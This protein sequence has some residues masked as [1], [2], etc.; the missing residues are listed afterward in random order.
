MPSAVEPVEHTNSKRHLELARE[1]AP[2]TLRVAGKLDE[3]QRISRVD[4]AAITKQIHDAERV[5]M[6]KTRTDLAVRMRKIQAEADYLRVQLRDP[7]IAS[8]QNYRDLTKAYELIGKVRKAL[9]P[10]I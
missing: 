2:R 6:T 7:R 4:E 5:A 9:A 10:S 1:H 3:P 8:R